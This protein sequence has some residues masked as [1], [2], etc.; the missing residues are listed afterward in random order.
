MLIFFVQE[1]RYIKQNTNQKRGKR[2]REKGV[3][4]PKTGDRKKESSVIEDLINSSELT[5]L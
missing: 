3:G 5:H 4:R 2:K 1:Q